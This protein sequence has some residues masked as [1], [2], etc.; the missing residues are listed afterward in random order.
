MKVHAVL[1]ATL[2]GDDE[3]PVPP[4]ASFLVLYER[5]LLGRTFIEQDRWQQAEVKAMQPEDEVP[6]L[7]SPEEKRVYLCPASSRLP[8]LLASVA[9]EIA[10]NYDVAGICLDNVDYPKGTPFIVGGEDLSPPY[11]YTLEVRR[12]MIRL[13]QVDPID[14][15]PG[16]VRDGED[17][18]AFALWDKFRRGHLTGLLSEV[19]T[20]F[21]ARKPDAVF[22]AT[23]SLDSDAQS[24]AHWAAL[25][26]L[27]A[28]LPY[29]HIRSRMGDEAA[30]LPKEDSDA[31]QGLH[32]AVVKNAAVIPAVAGLTR[33]ALPDQMPAIANVT[34][35]VKDS[36][37]KGYILT[38]DA[39][40]LTAAL[41]M[42]AE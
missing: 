17:A 6:Q 28:L 40:T 39:R 38:G 1:D 26:G 14:V 24:P 29:A 4:T 7:A 30:V 37:L 35:T 23:L 5:S 18:E 22:A 10:A 27:D 8:R 20:V 36:G 2:W 3:H 31:I 34:K 42:L 41:D 32:R 12:E 19:S 16:S 9:E 13:N 25:A 15:D 33:E 21:K 11:G